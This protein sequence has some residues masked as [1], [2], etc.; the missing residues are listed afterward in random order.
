MSVVIIM[1]TGRHAGHRAVA[2]TLSS[3][4][5]KNWEVHLVDMSGK[6]PM[7]EKFYEIVRCGP[8]FVITLDL[9]GFELKTELETPSLNSVPCRMAHILFEEIEE[10]A[11]ILKER[12]NFS[13]FFYCRE[14]VAEQIKGRYPD[15]P[16]I[17]GNDYLCET[18]REVRERDADEWLSDFLREAMVAA[19]GRAGKD[20]KS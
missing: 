16:N 19:G 5:E 14:K 1:D 6:E 3:I 2:D 12:F 8:P 17:R 13:M 18:Q 7:H 10:Y 4:L 20:G 15:V 9:A 11:G